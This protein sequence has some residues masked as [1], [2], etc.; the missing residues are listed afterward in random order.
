MTNNAA[1][2]GSYT[3]TGGQACFLTVEGDFCRRSPENTG[4]FGDKSRLLQSHLKRL[5]GPVE[6]DVFL[7]FSAAGD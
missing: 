7:A 6:G 2:G 3:P 1:H 5:I 4:K